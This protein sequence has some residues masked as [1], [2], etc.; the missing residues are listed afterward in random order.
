MSLVERIQTQIKSGASLAITPTGYVRAN[1]HLAL[2]AVI[3]QANLLDRADVVVL[4]VLDP[5]WLSKTGRTSIVAAI[6]RS[7]HPV[8]IALGDSD[9]DPMT[10]AGVLEGA[11]E[12]CELEGSPMFHKTDLVG[13]HLMAR[14]ALAVSVG[15][16]AS[17][18]RAPVPD[19]PPFARRSRRGPNILLWNLLRFR[20][21]MDMQ[22]DWFASIEAPVCNCAACLGQPIDRFG[23]ADYDCQEASQHNAIGLITYVN[24][25]ITHGGYA[26]YWPGKV[27]DAHAAHVELG[28]R[29]GKPIKIPRE[30]KAWQ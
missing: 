24:E 22:D 3:N 14:G 25:A 5:V 10:R 30:L 12:L 9:G 13:F 21:T 6:K 2:R 26:G 15:L 16:I 11:R 4:L 23:E 20:R 27:Y 1:D 29:V 7:K 18:R 28:S 19:K 17:K 8:A